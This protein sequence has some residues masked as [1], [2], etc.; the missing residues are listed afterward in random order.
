MADVHQSKAGTLAFQF[1][2]GEFLLIVSLALDG[3]T[4]SLQ[5]RL[6]RGTGA[7]THQLMFHLNAWAMV[8]LLLGESAW[9]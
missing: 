3:L 8:V 5:E 1:G 7:S 9:F 4:G 6:L 2:F